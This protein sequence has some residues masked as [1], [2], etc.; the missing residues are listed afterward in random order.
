MASRHADAGR[1]SSAFERRG[2]QD[3]FRAVPADALL[4]RL[5]GA[6]VLLMFV[7]SY[8]R[9]ALEQQR[10]AETLLPPLEAFERAARRAGLSPPPAT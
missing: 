6:D 5:G 9:S 8:G 2:A 3:R 10:Y 4:A 7:E 1:A